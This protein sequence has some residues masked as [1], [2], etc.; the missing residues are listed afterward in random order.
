MLG[1][2]ISPLNPVLI[3]ITVGCLLAALGAMAI[4][5]RRS[6]AADS[7]R[8]QL[9]VAIGLL[10]AS[11]WMEGALRLGLGGRIGACLRVVMLAGALAALI[12]FSV[13]NR[14]QNVPWR[15][16]RWAHLLAGALVV[17]A[18][19]PRLIG[20]ADFIGRC[21]VAWQGSALA[22]SALR[23]SRAAKQPA[24]GQTP[25]LAVY[26]LVACL[27]ASAVGLGV[28][29]APSLCLAAC[30]IWVRLSAEI[31]L[32]G[33]AKTFVVWGC[34]LALVVVVGIA[35]I[36]INQTSASRPTMASMTVGV[37]A[38]STSYDIDS[39]PELSPSK[40]AT[41]SRASQ[42]GFAAAPIALLIG[43]IWGLSRLP[44]AH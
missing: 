10:A 14:S 16:R 12:E 17:A 29:A 27:V 37:G 39:S 28:I 30:A 13:S 20:Y 31:R 7:S 25:L 36:A 26:S 40:R 4:A 15:L 2:Y 34:P 44:F 32:T 24:A 33:P 19:A 43:A 9:V 22:I 41:P 42:L 5:F 38:D 1:L 21:L 35:G 11:S 3:P 6:F 23:N 8:W 18:L